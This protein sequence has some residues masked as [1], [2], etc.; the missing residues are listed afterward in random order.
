M[1]T[2]RYL[3]FLDQAVHPALGL[4]PLALKDW[5]EID[6]Q[7]SSQLRLKTQLLA[8]CYGDV[9][10]A[11]PNTFEA[12]AEVLDCL[13]RHLLS[14]FPE[15]YEAQGNH[16][17]NRR[18][19]QRWC[20]DEFAMAPLELAARLVQ[21]DLCLLLP[22]NK[23]I[24]QLSAA[25][26]CFPLRWSLREKLGQPVG[27][28]HHRVPTYA[29]KLERPVDNVFARLR[30]NY[31]GVRFNWSIVD[32]PD[33]FLAQDKQITAFN[34]A[35]TAENAGQWL[36]LRVERQTLRRLT[37]CGGVLFTIRTYIHPL[38]QVTAQPQASEGLLQAVQALQPDMQV[39][40]NLLPFR[41]ALL[42]YLEQRSLAEV[43]V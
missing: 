42:M 33:L 25:C 29:K 34:P 38:A 36:W 24:Y 28:I 40:K 41:E 15:V 22:G 8:E 43:S 31:P 11:F 37:A 21:E 18:T 16:L 19:G 39:Y 13:L 32:A 3:P 35:I 27:Q 10:A 17:Y 30:E 23:G 20:R 12:Q 9:F 6:D 7:F 2:L 5:I 14:H 26:V 4:K 1:D